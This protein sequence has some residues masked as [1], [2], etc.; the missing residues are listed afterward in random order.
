MVAKPE[1]PASQKGSPMF[2]ALTLAAVALAAATTGYILFVLIAD[3]YT[4][5]SGDRVIVDVETTGLDAHTERIIEVAMVRVD[6]FGREVRRFVTLINPNR[7]TG[8]EH[9]HGITTAMVAGAPTFDMI[10]TNVAAMMK[11]ATF[12]AH[13]VS[14]DLPFLIVEL[15]R[16]GVK[17]PKVPTF[18]TLATARL[19]FTEGRHNLKATAERFGISVPLSHRAEADAE[20]TLAIFRRM[21]GE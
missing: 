17:A 19:M 21:T 18:C 14:F 9:I 10:A 11:G 5:G 16:A 6:R 12:V 20:I 2:T 3:L 7:D 4:N 8:A 15:H 1:V 13:N